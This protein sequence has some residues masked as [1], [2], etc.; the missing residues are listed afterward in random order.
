MGW[1]P[2][3]LAYKL[4]DRGGRLIEVPAAYPYS[5]QTFQP[6]RHLLCGGLKIE[7]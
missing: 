2:G 6:N 5:S 4:A 3:M 1:F 7:V